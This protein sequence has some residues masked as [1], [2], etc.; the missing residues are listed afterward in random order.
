[1]P[2]EAPSRNAIAFAYV[3]AATPSTPGWDASFAASVSPFG[4]PAVF[5]PSSTTCAS[6]PEMRDCTSLS[7]P[8]MT[9]S[10]VSSAVTPT[11]TPAMEMPVSSVMKP[12]LGRLRR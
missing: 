6:V 3:K 8:F 1:M 2:S 4:T 7:N 12:V 9:A 11:A 10:T 5:S